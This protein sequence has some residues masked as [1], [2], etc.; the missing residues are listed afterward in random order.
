MTELHPH[1]IDAPDPR[2][3]LLVLT[4]RERECVE[5]RCRGLKTSAV[6][7]ELGIEY[8]TAKNHMAAAFKKLG[9]SSIAE[10]CELV[11]RCHER[12]TRASG[13]DDR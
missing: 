4:K 8:D 5:L 2:T 13:T 6:A 1:G 9:V 12:D 7:R 10:T 11:G 3:V